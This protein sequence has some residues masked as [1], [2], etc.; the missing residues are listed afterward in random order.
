MAQDRTQAIYADDSNRQAYSRRASLAVKL[1]LGSYS[2]GDHLVTPRYSGAA[3]LTD[4][5]ESGYKQWAILDPFYVPLVGP[6]PANGTHAGLASRPIA[7]KKL[8]LPQ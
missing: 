6:K 5:L 3:L 7:R 1:D 4:S 2:V 8:C